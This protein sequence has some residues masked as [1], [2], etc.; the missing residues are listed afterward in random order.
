MLLNLQR[1][2]VEHERI[3]EKKRIEENHTSQ[4]QLMQKLLDA[5]AAV[6]PLDIMSQY[7]VMEGARM[8]NMLLSFR[9][10]GNVFSEIYSGVSSQRTQMFPGYQQPTQL[11]PHNTQAGY[12][13]AAQLERKVLRS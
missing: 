4:M 12:G 10:M 1:A 7:H 9:D 3:E 11:A 6:K 2:M 13:R 5:H 8:H